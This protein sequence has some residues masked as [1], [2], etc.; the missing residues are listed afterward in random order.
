LALHL[1][2]RLEPYKVPM[3][4]EQVE[5]VARTFN[6]KLDRKYYQR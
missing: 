5:K 4:Y 1:K 6:G 2:E 3:L